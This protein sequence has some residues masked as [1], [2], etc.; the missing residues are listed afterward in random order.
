MLSGL[1]LVAAC[2]PPTGQ[3]Q[4]I[5]GEGAM[6]IEFERT[7]GVAGIRFAANVD[8]DTL[9]ADEAAKLRKLVDDSNFFSLPARLKTPTPSADRFQYRLT[10]RTPE[11]SHTVDVGEGAAPASLRPL[12][13]WLMAA[14]RKPH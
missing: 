10:V 7:G 13:D 2:V 6:Q 3:P 12:I 1:L 11:R 9:T 14:A 5:G 4:A 8:T